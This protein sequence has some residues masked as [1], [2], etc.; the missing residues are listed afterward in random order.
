MLGIGLCFL[1]GCVTVL[2]EDVIKKSNVVSF[3]E[4]QQAN[5]KH[6]GQV[7][8][9]GGTI[10]KVIEGNQ[11]EVIQRPL[12]YRMEPEY[13]DRT[14]GRFIVQFDQNLDD[15]QFPKDRGITVAG[16]VVGNKTLPFDQT[17]YVYPLLRVREYHVWPE[18]VLIPM[19]DYHMRHGMMGLF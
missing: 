4:L 6:V 16:E 13:G 14:D 17:N 10:A 19:P 11:L 7:V 9:L 3:Q 8:I 5:E 18:M 15:K 1:L 2:S 12:G